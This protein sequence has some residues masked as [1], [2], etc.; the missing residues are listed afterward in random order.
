MFLIFIWWDK[1]DL[2]F[3]F[4]VRNNFP[5]ECINSCSLP[6]YINVITVQY[7]S[8]GLNNVQAQIMYN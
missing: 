1:D 6:P 2:F 4:S 7:T 5:W 3:G 8:E